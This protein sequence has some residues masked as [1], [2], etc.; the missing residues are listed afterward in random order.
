MED[1]EHYRVAIPDVEL[2]RLK[3]RLE[4]TTLP[5]ELEDALWDMGAPLADVKRLTAYWK[6]EFDWR[7]AESKI[8]EMP[9][10]RTS[11]KVDG[12]ESLDIHFVHQVSPVKNAI[13]LLFCHGCR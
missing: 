3:Q 1:I 10:F 4:L 6:E 2:Q 12:F 7:K 8:N 9:Q 13:P 5:D 11:I